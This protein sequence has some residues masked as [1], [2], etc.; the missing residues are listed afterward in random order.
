MNS[1]K[2][3]RCVLRSRASTSATSTGEQLALA[4][5]LTYVPRRIAFENA[6]MLLAARVDGDVLIRAHQSPRVTRS[7]SSSVV[8]PARIFCTPSSRMLGVSVRA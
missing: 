6:A 7:T 3:P 8:S 4:Q 2:L 5:E 1:E